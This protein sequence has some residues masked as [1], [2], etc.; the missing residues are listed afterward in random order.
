MTSTSTTTI[1]NQNITEHD[2]EGVSA[3]FVC[4]INHPEVGHY[5]YVAD[6]ET[7]DYAGRISDGSDCTFETLAEATEYAIRRNAELG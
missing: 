2:V 6:T 3:L 5:F 1:G 4:E 7:G